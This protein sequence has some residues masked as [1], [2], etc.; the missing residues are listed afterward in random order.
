VNETLARI[1]GARIARRHR[2]SAQL[3]TDDNG[4]LIALPARL[5]LPDAEWAQ[6]LRVDGFDDDLLAGLRS[7]HLLRHHFRYVANT[8]LLV[9][10]RAGGRTL[11]RGALAWNAQ[12]IFDR[13]FEADRDFPLIRETIRVVTR[14]LLDAPGARAYLEAL[15]GEPCVMHPPAATPFTFGIVTSSFG[16]T[17]VIDDR[18]AMVEALHERV[19]ALLGEGPDDADSPLAPPAP[20]TDRRGQPTLVPLR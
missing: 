6:L 3:T 17:V 16:D 8:G 14:D 2:V 13:L 12:K 15:E 5:T 1:A 4:F 9:L 11:R 18:A 20:P 19:L 7:S 10:R